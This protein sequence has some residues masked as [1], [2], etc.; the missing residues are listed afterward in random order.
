MTEPPANIPERWNLCKQARKFRAAVAGGEGDIGDG[1]F[2]LDVNRV[3]E[4]SDGIA[5]EGEWCV[6]HVRQIGGH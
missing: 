2:G 3:V 4:K 6:S 1:T 5:T